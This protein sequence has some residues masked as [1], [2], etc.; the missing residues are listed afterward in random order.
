VNEFTLLN[1][2]G[3]P[4]KD[5]TTY[6]SMIGDALDSPGQT[7]HETGPNVGA[8]RLDLIGPPSLKF[9]TEFLDT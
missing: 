1:S 8:C 4:N 9:L 5:R 7:R 3:R 2:S 6:M